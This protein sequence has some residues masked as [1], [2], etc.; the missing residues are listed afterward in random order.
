MTQVKSWV[1]EL[2]EEVLGKSPFKVGDIVK[3][4]SGRMVK[5]I[6]GKYWGAHGLSNFWYWREI[7][8]NGTPSDNVE[9][10]YGW[11]AGG[12]ASGA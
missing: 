7:L 5:I 1:I 6:S 8:P 12:E 4:P 3:H 2:T 9:H 11:R 10:G